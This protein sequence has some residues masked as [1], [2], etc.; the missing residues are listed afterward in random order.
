MAHGPFSRYE[1]PTQTKADAILQARTGEIWGSAGRFSLAP[2]VRAY[3]KSLPAGQRGIN[4]STTTAPDRWS[5]SPIEA[6]WY[7]PA[8]PGVQKRQKGSVEYACIDAVVQNLQP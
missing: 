1:S 3:P 7:Y 6:K 4:F 2:C 5:S 8:T